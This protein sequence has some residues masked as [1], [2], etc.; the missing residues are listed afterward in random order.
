VT[1]NHDSSLS[2][3]LGSFSAFLIIINT[4]IGVGIFIT[5]GIIAQSIPFPFLIFLAWI[6]GG[7]ICISGA[8]SIAELA[9][10]MPHAGGLY[11][12]LR[13]AYG[14]FAGFLF[15]WSAFT[16]TFSGSIAL[17]ASG[18]VSYSAEIFPILSEDLVFYGFSVDLQKASAIFLIILFSLFNYSGVR[19]GGYFQNFLSFLKLSAIG[20]FVFA[21]FIFGS[22]NTGNFIRFFPESICDYAGS[23]V[24][25]LIPVY[26]AFSGW[27]ASTYIGSEIKSASRVIPRSIIHGVLC[28]IAIYLTVNAVYMF[29]VSPSDMKGLVSVGHRTSVVLFGE[30]GSVILTMLILM[31][32]AGCLSAIILTGP[33]IYYTMANHGLFFRQCAKVHSVHRTPYISIIAQAVW[34]CILILS[35]TFKTLLAWVTFVMLLM[36][37]LIVGAV[38]IM[39]K[40]IPCREKST[41]YMVTGYPFTPIVFM[42]FT[43]TIIITTLFQNPFESLAGILILCAGLPVYFSSGRKAPKA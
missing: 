1:Y 3:S 11:I 19:T 6:I 31:C 35:G 18:F 14:N 5:P 43:A 12:Y 9:S 40:K 20:I 30:S 29:A 41:H 24:A 38:F 7:L 37:I 2:R 33:R 13:E 32:I 42:A 27:D 15:G 28:V 25:A 17:L 23:F 36:D 16:V 4:I 34:S 10:L 8:L 39:R 26:F 21:G 22:G